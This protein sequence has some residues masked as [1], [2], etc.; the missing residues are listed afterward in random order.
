MVSQC[1]SQYRVH[2]GLSKDDSMRLHVVNIKWS[3][4]LGSCLVVGIFAS[5]AIWIALGI[6]RWE[7][8]R[9]VAAS[10]IGSGIFL[11]IRY[12]VAAAKR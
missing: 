4:I 7:V 5:H 10:L 3:L 6:T 11:M 12:A 9:L 2:A 8:L 1:S